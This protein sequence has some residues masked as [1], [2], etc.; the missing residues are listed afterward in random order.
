MAN[1]T[2]RAMVISRY[3]PPEVLRE[4]RHV[5]PAA[6]REGEAALFAR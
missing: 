4:E 3:G 2:M 6:P 1:E 5:L